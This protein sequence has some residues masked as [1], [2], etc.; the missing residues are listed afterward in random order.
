MRICPVCEHVEPPYG[1]PRIWAVL[2]DVQ[3]GVYIATC[4]CEVCD[5]EWI[6]R[7]N[8]FTEDTENI[9]YKFNGDEVLGYRG[10]RGGHKGP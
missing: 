2:N 10:V 6:E 4:A 1:P 7:Y 5:S 3:D 9:V 8:S